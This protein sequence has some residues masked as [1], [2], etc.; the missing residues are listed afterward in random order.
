MKSVFPAAEHL[1]SLLDLQS[2]LHL[3]SKGP[4]EVRVSSK[5][6]LTSLLT[7]GGMAG[8]LFRGYLPRFDFLKL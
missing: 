8:A 5:P 1:S 6:L 3:S 2:I 7:T 4:D